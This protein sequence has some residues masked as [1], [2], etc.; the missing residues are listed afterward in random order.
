MNFYCDLQTFW[1]TSVFH[2]VTFRFTS[3]EICYFSMNR[4]CTTLFCYFL[5]HP[6]FLQYS[7]ELATL[8]TSHLKMVTN[9]YADQC[10][11]TPQCISIFSR[12]LFQ[13]G[14]PLNA[15]GGVLYIPL[16][17][18]SHVNTMSEDAVSFHQLCW[19]EW[20]PAQDH[21]PMTAQDTA[22]L[23]PLSPLSLSL[24]L[25]PVTTPTYLDHTDS[26]TARRPPVTPHRP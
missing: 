1:N 15:N 24:C 22:F 3:E 11:S 13:D 4:Y 17:C 23:Y 16:V 26:T 8:M 7:R 5:D 12:L 25:T 20:V 14:L 18:A 10:H 21:V 6:G 2:T 19:C 9:W